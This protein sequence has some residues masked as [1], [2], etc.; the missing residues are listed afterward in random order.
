MRTKDLMTRDVGS[1]IEF[2]MRVHVDLGL[3]EN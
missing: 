2:E 1:E 3:W